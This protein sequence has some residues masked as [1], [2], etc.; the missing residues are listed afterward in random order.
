M[1]AGLAAFSETSLVNV[2]FYTCIYTVA[3][4]GAFM[5]VH[6]FE[7]RHG[8][9]EISSLSGVVN[10]YPYLSILLLV[11]MVSLTGL[12][13]TAGFTAKFLIFSSIW[14]SYTY[15]NN[16]WLLALLAFGLVNT[17]VALFY[18]LKIPY[19]MIFKPMSEELQTD[20]NYLYFENYLSAFLVVA[21][22]LLFF[23]PDWLMGFINIINFAF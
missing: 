4:I 3:G 7:R 14:E 22:L 23:R 8:K 10:S 16:G 6:F 18:Y 13:P 2:I 11:M 17:V 5:I 19:Y 1:L 12:P 21:V 15:N 20:N 9:K